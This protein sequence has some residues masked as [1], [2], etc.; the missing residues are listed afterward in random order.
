MADDLLQINV[1]LIDNPFGIKGSV[2]QNY[3]GSYTVFINARLSY[4]QQKRNMNMK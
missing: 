3:D 4:E 2:T 1:V